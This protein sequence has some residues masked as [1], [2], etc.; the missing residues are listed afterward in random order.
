VTVH[1]LGDLV[2]HP[3]PEWC[4]DAVRRLSAARGDHNVDQLT[5]TV[6][7]GLL[8]SI[9]GVELRITSLV[10]KAKM[11]QNKAPEVVEA[12]IDGLEGSGGTATAAWMRDNSLPRARTKAELLTG[13]R[14]RIVETD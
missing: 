5:P 2:V 1:A 12:V 7:D 11:S 9:V 8:R 13:I 3:E 14:R 4:A 6:L 10:G